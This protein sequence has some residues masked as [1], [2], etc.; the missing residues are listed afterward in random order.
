MSILAPRL[1]EGD[2]IRIVAPSSSMKQSFI[3]EE[4]KEYATKNLE[5]MGFKVTFGR[6]VNELDEFNSTTITHRLKD[7]HDAFRDKNVKAVFTVIGGLNSNQLLQHLDYGLIK[8]NPKIFCGYSDITA[9]QNAIF[10]K[11]GLITYYGPHYFTFGVKHD[12]EYT[13]TYFRACLMDS[14]P[15]D[16]SPGK[17]VVDWSDGGGLF[18]Y[19]NS[20]IWVIQKGKIKGSIIGGNL[21]TFNLL[22]G[23][24]FMPDVVGSI[25]FVE[26][27]NGTKVRTLDRNLQSLLQQKGADKIKGLVIGRFQKESKMPLEVLKKVLSTKVLPRGI[28][29]I[30][31]VDF[32]HTYPMITYPIGGEV[33]L[34]VTNNKPIIR[35]LRH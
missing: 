30:A 17:E 27:D 2:E 7:F 6:Y 20:G 14:K 9:L 15:F 26:D 31:N 29:I 5:A 25:L 10:A 18:G 4:V 16:I 11:T 28:P 24:K 8:K 19:K 33:E 22:Q 3:T 13:R 34:N 32:G 21:C 1:K 23:T 35:I 12:L